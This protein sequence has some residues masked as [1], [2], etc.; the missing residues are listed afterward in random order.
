MAKKRV[1][2]GAFYCWHCGD[3]VEK[4]RE[5]CPACGASYESAGRFGS[6]TGLGAGGVGWSDKTRHPAFK[7]FTKN[8]W[9]AVLVWDGALTILIPGLM[10]ASGDIKADAEGLRIL[11]IIVGIIWLFGIGFVLLKRG[12][13]K[14]NWDGVV[15]NKLV[16]H[17]EK[18]RKDSNGV[19][20]TRYYDVYVLV[21]RQHSGK[22]RRFEQI[23]LP[24][25]YDQF[26]VGDNVRFHGNRHLNC[27]E[28]YD[29][30][31]DSQLFCVSCGAG[32]DPRADYCDACGCPLLKGQPA[33]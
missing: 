3:A 13:N 5:T 24:G 23:D 30:R 27:L 14:R 26:Q 16:E 20:Q 32:H 4:G 11:A 10:L 15:E 25:V 1:G 7:R 8:Y 19:R 12:R 18:V 28:K 17:H 22:L 33:M 9:L 6:G 31:F 29:K 2:Y 21:I